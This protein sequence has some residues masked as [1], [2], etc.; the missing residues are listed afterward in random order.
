M[1]VLALHAHSLLSLP[2]GEYC[3]RASPPLVLGVCCCVGRWPY[4]PTPPLPHT[5]VV[6]HASRGVCSA[7]ATVSGTPGGMQRLVCARQRACTQSWRCGRHCSGPDRQ[8]RSCA[9]NR[10]GYDIV[11]ELFANAT[12]ARLNVVRLYAH[13]TDPDH[14]FQVRRTPRHQTGRASP[15]RSR[16]P[17][18]A[19]CVQ[20]GLAHAC[21]WQMRAGARGREL[22]T[23]PL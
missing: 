20:P 1:A 8:G 21:G 10:R 17:A 2:A 18:C 13:T 4:P 19:S 3:D 15:P 7:G 22:S 12:R 5:V 14:P 11:H 16:T 6:S 23:P 9:G